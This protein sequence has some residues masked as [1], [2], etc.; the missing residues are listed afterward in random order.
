MFSGVKISTGMIVWVAELIAC[1][2]PSEVVSVAGDGGACSTWR[3]PIGR[4]TLS[5][6]EQTALQ[7]WEV[8]RS[9]IGRT[10]GVCVQD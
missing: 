8:K 10:G 7:T 6:V 9:S 2:L 3:S 5:P 1:P 4:I